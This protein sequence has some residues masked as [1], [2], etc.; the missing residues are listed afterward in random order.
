[1]W[2]IPNRSKSRSRFWKAVLTALR[3]PAPA[4]A[5]CVVLNALVPPAA[6]CSA[7]DAVPA[8]SQLVSL[9][10]D[11]WLLATDPKNVGRDEQWVA[12]K[13]PVENSSE[14]HS[15]SLRGQRT[16]RRTGQRRRAAA[17]TLP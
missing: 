12:L 6:E 3:L 9:D 2:R 16:R 7:A 8:S 13:V 17:A 5:M 1:M 11:G 10:G 14:G 15:G 4:C